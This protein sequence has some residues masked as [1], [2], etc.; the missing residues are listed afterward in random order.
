MLKVAIVEDVK[1]DADNLEKNLRKYEAETGIAIETKVFDNVQVFL[2]NYQPVYDI[3]FMDIMM[4]YMNGIKAAA[5]LRKQDECVRLIF[6]TD[7]AKYAINGYEVDATDF[8]VKPVTYHALKLRLDKINLMW[9]RSVPSV[10]IHIPYKGTK[11]V[12]S[13]E[14]Y[15]IEVRNK[16][17]TYHTRQGNYTVRSD[18]LK[19]LEAQLKDAGFMRCSSSYLI[20][21]KWCNGFNG[22]YIYVAGDEI[23]ISRRQKKECI[24]A[25]YLTFAGGKDEDKK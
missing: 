11:V 4:P 16:D 21:L 2:L 12:P 6:V 1:E 18:G 7:M 14:V 17:M 15:Y 20:N 22:D 3:V 19:K 8:F 10:K 23:K 24:N 13:S 5:E 9:E 25:L